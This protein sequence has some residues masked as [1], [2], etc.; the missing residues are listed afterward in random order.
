MKADAVKYESEEA[1]ERDNKMNVDI[2]NE[3]IRLI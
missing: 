2:L 1:D 3:K